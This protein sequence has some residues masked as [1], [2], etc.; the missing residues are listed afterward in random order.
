MSGQYRAALI[1]LGSIARAHVAG[2]RGVEEVEIVAGADPSPHAREAFQKDADVSDLYDDVDKMLS[3]VQPDLVSVCTW[4]GLHAQGVIACAEAGVKGIICEKPMCV[5]LADADKMIA[6]C[7]KHGTKLV[8]GHQRRHSGGWEQAREM[9][10][11]GVLG[12][13]I[14]VDSRVGDGLLNCGTHAIDAIRYALGDP[15]TEWVMG[16]VERRTDRFERNVPIEDAC[17]GLIHFA[18]GP[19]AL[20]QVDL[21]PSSGGW[22]TLRGREGSLQVSEGELQ[23]VNADSNG[24][25][26]IE[27]PHPHCHISQVKDLIAWIEGGPEHRSAPEHGRA[28]VEIMMSIYESARRHEIIRMPLTESGYPLLSMI[29]DGQLPVQLPGT[30]DIRSF[31]VRGSEEAQLH[32]EMRDQ[33]KSHQEYISELRRRS[34]S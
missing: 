1:G 7:E 9:V 27:T 15:A 18:G 32:Q 22:F 3:G 16:A 17:M 28:A 5:G 20:I 14:S 8:I 30:Y 13:I 26:K 24:L 34:Q 21:A 10:A 4:H 6:T 12:E 33:E 31:L 2:Y 11:D 19:Q 23:L 29:E 25:K